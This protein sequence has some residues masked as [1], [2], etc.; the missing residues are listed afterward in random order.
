MNTGLTLGMSFVRTIC[1]AN[2][3][4]DARKEWSSPSF[5]RL[6]RRLQCRGLSRLSRYINPKLDICVS[7]RFI[8]MYEYIAYRLFGLLYV[9]SNTRT[10]EQ[11][12][13]SAA[14]GLLSVYA[15]VRLILTGNLYPKGI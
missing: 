3:L 5:G 1:S 2:P 4:D 12:A 10:R 8:L 15:L 7:T 6:N 13:V 14:I 9:I 11:G